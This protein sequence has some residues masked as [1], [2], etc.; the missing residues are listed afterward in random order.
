ML[1]MFEQGTQGGITQ[2]AYRYVQ[3]NNKYMGNRFSPVKESHCLQY[4]HANNLY[5]W[6]MV[7]KLSTDRFKWVENPDELKGNISKLAKEA[8][9]GYLLELDVSY[10]N[11]LPNLHNDLPFMWENRKINGVQKLVPNLYDKKKYVIHMAAL[12]QAL[13]HGLVLDKFH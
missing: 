7:Q 8:G 13:K 10:P 2:A 1:L 12:R 4:L 5:G 3:A 9:N 11:D 6:S